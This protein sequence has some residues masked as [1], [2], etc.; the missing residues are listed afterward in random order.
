MYLACNIC[1]DNRQR[2][3]YYQGYRFTGKPGRLEKSG[4]SK[5]VLEMSGKMQE[6]RD[7]SGNLC[8]QRKFFIATCLV[9][10]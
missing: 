10:L 5:M 2:F 7:K 9:C 6:V 1:S 3:Y 8:S 4:N